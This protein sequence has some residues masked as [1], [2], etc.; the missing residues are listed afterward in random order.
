[1]TVVPNLPFDY[2]PR[3]GLEV[4]FDFNALDSELT[5][6]GLAWFAPKPSPFEIDRKKRED[7]QANRDSRKRRKDAERRK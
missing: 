1:V 5:P 3:Q 4:R 6:N 2:D 7:R